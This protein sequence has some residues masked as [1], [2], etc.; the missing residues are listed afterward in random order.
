LIL[1]YVYFK[2]AW[3]EYPMWYLCYTLIYIVGVNK[4]TFTLSTNT[5]INIFFYAIIWI[6]E[7]SRQCKECVTQT[8]NYNS[9]TRRLSSNVFCIY[10]YKPYIPLLYGS[11]KITN[12]PYQIILFFWIIAWSMFSLKHISILTLFKIKI[13][14]VD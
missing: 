3:D 4:F 14:S 8:T 5:T 10:H 11:S 13:V 7:I 6:M 1:I 9:L 12:F 2:V